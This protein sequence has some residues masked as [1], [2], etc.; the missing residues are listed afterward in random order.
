MM[1]LKRKTVSHPIFSLHWKNPITDSDLGSS[2]QPT[3]VGF[4]NPAPKS[5]QMVKRQAHTSTPHFPSGHR[6][7]ARNSFSPEQPHLP[8]RPV[9]GSLPSPRQYWHPSQMLRRS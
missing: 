8:H 5:T 9:P 4:F 1:K 3:S 6:S 2:P 7:V